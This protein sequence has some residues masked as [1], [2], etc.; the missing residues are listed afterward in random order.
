MILKIFSLIFLV[1][2]MKSSFRQTSLTML[3]NDT[4]QKYHFLIPIV[5]GI[6]PYLV[7]GEY[8][9]FPLNVWPIED[10]IRHGPVVAPLRVVVHHLHKTDS[11]LFLF[12]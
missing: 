8:T 10:R 7:V 9:K 5:G 2:L 3:V 1:A 4:V 6:I 12:L 11:L